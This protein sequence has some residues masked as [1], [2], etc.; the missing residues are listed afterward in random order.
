MTIYTWSSFS[1]RRNST[2]QP[3]GGTSK[4]VTLKS[5]T[6]VIHPVFLLNSFSLS[7]NYLQW[8]NRF[9]YIDDIILVNNNLAEYHC[10]VDALASWK[11][12]IGNMTEFVARSA[13][14]GDGYLM[15]MFYPVKVGLSSYAVDTDGS[16]SGEIDLTTGSVVIG[17]ING[18]SGGNTGAVEYF[19]LMDYQIAPFMNYMFS[20]AWLDASMTDI[21]LATQKQLINPFQYVVSAVWFPFERSYQV[22]SSIEFGWWDSGITGHK[23]T[24]FERLDKMTGSITLTSHPEAGSRGEYLNGAPF[25]TRDLYMWGFGKLVLDP[26]AFVKGEK[27]IY[28]LSIDLC[29]G[30]A[31]LLLE[32]GTSTETAHE[33]GKYFTSWGVPI[34][35]GQI[36]QQ[37]MDQGAVTVDAISSA[38]TLD[39]A[40][41]ASAVETAVKNMYPRLSTIGS[42][43]SIAG[44]TPSL[45]TVISEFR[46]QTPMDATHNGRP[47][48]QNVQINTLSG[49][50]KT[51]NADVD[52]PCTQEER[53]TIA[54]YMDGGFYYE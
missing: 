17:V 27:L 9:Y 28:T 31:S 41:A 51:E 54:A 11:T 10:S 6:S 1:K 19:H 14:S 13:S 48:C 42:T 36:T 45:P 39:F 5:P 40:G 53:D 7:D 22:D 2:K 25:T 33:I 52:L 34:Q 16:Q 23:I 37:I 24:A 49:Y 35:L 46:S 12:S 26:A 29:E 44:F 47:L 38:L 20:D 50:I 43:G 3:T 8:D 30:S 15:D 18:N 4:S 32:A 21:T